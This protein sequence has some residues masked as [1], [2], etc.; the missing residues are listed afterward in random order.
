MGIL[1]RYSRAGFKTDHFLQKD[2]AAQQV[3]EKGRTYA[4]C[5]YEAPAFLVY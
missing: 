4:R 2:P 5:V 3:C 1:L